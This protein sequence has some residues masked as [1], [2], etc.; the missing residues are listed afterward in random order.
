MTYKHFVCGIVITAASVVAVA[1]AAD[2]GPRGAKMGPSFGTLDADGSGEITQA[3]LDAF[4][5]SRFAE[6]DTDGDGGIS[7]EEM[8]AHASAKA[9]KRHDRLYERFDAN[10]DGK[11]SPDEMPKGRG[12]LMDRADADKSGTIS[13]E[14]FADMRK[15][16]GGRARGHKN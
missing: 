9:S 8:A 2:S 1:A 15:R 13:E 11:L 6:L 3:E 12:S 16:F 4:A 7:K 5:Q 14:E 10:A